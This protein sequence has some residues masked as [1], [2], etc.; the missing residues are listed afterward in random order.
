MQISTLPSGKNEVF[1]A[2]RPTLY[3]VAYEIPG[4]PA[5]AEDM[6][7]ECFLRWENTEVANVRSP[8]VF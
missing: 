6:V 7:Q 5:D 4:N 1:I 2:L 3:A 8:K